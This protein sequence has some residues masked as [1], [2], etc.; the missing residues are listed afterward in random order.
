MPGLRTKSLLECINGNHGVGRGS[1]VGVLLAQCLQ[2]F[3]EILDESENP[4]E[5]AIDDVDVAISVSLKGG[6]TVQI[7]GQIYDLRF[8]KE[9]NVIKIFLMD[10]LYNV[11]PNS[12]IV[13][14]LNDVVALNSLDVV[15]ARKN[16]A[17]REKLDTQNE[18]TPEKQDALDQIYPEQ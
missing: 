16:Q 17:T 6:A 4:R 15:T 18:I 8:N 12:A 7:I 1:A 3:A 11:S 2:G 13:F 9:G 14:S 10:R 5:C